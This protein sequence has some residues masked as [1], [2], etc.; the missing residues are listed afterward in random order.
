MGLDPTADQPFGTLSAGERRRTSIARALMPDPD[1]LLLDEPT[2]SLDLPAR[3]LLVR[4]LEDLGR[5]GRPRAIVLV[6]H[7]LEEIPA[8]FD[9]ALVLRDGRVVAA[10]PV[11]TVLRDDVLTS[12][13]GIP[14]LV[15]ER[16][17]RW[18][19]RMRRPPAR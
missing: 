16:D 2:A 14:V 13:Y 17:G 18:A 1:L 9:H 12:A 15:E 10:G 5:D 8:G 7:H 19:A 4:D 11:A 3:E 6:S